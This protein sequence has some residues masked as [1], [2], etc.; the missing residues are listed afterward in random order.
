VDDRQLP[1]QGRPQAAAAAR[2]QTGLA[3]LPGAPNLDFFAYPQ[4]RRFDTIIGKPPYVRYQDIQPPTKAL[5]PRAVRGAER[6]GLGRHRLHVRRPP[7]VQK[8]QEQAVG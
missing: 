2:D 1:P 3:P 8:E 6:R 5:L 7:S 4:P